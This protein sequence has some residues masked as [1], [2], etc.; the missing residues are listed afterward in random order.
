MRTTTSLS[1]AGSAPLIG[2]GE[3]G[4][5]VAYQLTGTFSGTVTFEGSVDGTNYVAIAAEPI[6]GG[7]SVTTA[8]AA[9][10]WRVRAG[11]LHS[12]RARVSTYTSGTFVITQDVA[13][14][15]L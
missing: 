13:D 9:G 5:I 6:G 2:G 3:E 7:S 14:G 12:V 4:N 11:G 10:I 8:T 15:T 1:A